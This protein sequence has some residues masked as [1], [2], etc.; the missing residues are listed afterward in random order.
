MFL[1]DHTLLMLCMYCIF[2][3]LYI[4]L[5]ILFGIACLAYHTVINVALCQPLYI[6]FIV[7]SF[8]IK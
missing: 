5:R 3:M 7:N 6:E 2:D 8:D 4:Y 1:C